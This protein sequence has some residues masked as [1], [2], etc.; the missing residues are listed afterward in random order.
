M[1]NIPKPNKFLGA[2]L[3]I[4]YYSNSRYL[5][6]NK[7]KKIMSQSQN[8]GKQIIKNIKFQIKKENS[9]NNVKNILS[10]YE[11]ADIES[12]ILNQI[13]SKNYQTILQKDKNISYYLTT[14]NKELKKEINKKKLKLKD[15]LTKI[16]NKSISLANKINSY[17]YISVDKKLKRNQSQND[18]RKKNNDFLENLGIKIEFNENKN[19]INI[20]IDKAWK[21]INKI[22]KGKQNNIDNIL[23]QKI[24]NNILNLKIENGN[25]KLIRGNSK[26]SHKNEIKKKDEKIK[27]NKNEKINN[28]NN[29]RINTSYTP[30]KNNRLRMIEILNRS[31]ICS[32][33]MNDNNQGDPKTKS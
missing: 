32:T 13:K 12:N 1:K 18:I 9:Y 5:K 23:K 20:D 2:N 16:I 7:T 29:N 15:D 22:S 33:T 27:P 30:Y 19:V 17:K 31:Y 10:A 24:I 25:K 4:P 26:N 3:F 28:N 6:K 14:E 21:Y 11:K 8:N